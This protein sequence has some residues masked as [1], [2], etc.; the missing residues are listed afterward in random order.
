MSGG[1]ERAAVRASYDALADEYARHVAGELEHKPFDR[2]FLERFAARMGDAGPV[3]DVGCGP[4]HVAAYLHARGLDARGIDLS[5]EMVEQ[6]RARFPGIAFDTGDMTALDAPDASWAAAVAFYSLIH[7]PR[8]EIGGALRELRRVLR[9]GGLL[10]AAFH[11]GE[12]TRHF[13]ELWGVPIDLDFR[14]FTSAEMQGW[15]REARFEIESLEERDPYP[16]V[17]APTTRCYIV[18]RAA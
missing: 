14:F 5:P 6:A 17:E 16:D 2:A 15:L 13:D 4:G 7:L 18:A 1:A 12:E 3:V 9:P 8:E 10:L 11:V